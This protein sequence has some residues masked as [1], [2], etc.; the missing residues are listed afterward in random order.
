MPTE[1]V[2]EV[3]RFLSSDAPKSKLLR[4]F[5]V[6]QSSFLPADSERP[7]MDLPD[8][9][10]PSLDRPV[11]L[12][13]FNKLSAA[14][15]RGIVSKWWEKIDI[16]EKRSSTKELGRL[17]R[18]VEGKGHNRQKLIGF[19]LDKFWPQGL[20]LSQISDLDFCSLL[21]QPDSF[22]WT[23]MA[24]ESKEIDSAVFQVIPE[25]LICALKQDLQ[26]LFTI[27]TCL[28]PHPELPLLVL[29]VQLFDQKRCGPESA[30][31]PAPAYNSTRKLISRAPTYVV[32]PFNISSVGFSF[33]TDLYTKL[34]INSICK[35]VHS[36][37][38]V[39]L[40]KVDKLPVRNL[41]TVAFLHGL[42]RYAN[43]QGVWRAY[44][45][46][47]VDSS[48][49]DNPHNHEIVQGREQLKW[50]LQ[51]Q[52]GKA[53]MRFKGRTNI[54]EPTATSAEKLRYKSLLPVPRVDFIIESEKS[55]E[56]QAK[57]KLS[58]W[59]TD[60]FGGLHELCDKGYMDINRVPG[61]LTGENGP[62]SGK[63]INGEFYSEDI[64][65]RNL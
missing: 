51:S 34:I 1:I 12:R 40:A 33:G 48:P 25:Q 47:K 10:I 43:A 28:R 58:L 30:Q 64:S 55:P 31:N 13:K 23:L 37:N 56:K 15:I 19:I 38:K 61:W 39:K 26:P 6:N 32:L 54:P 63:I 11:I 20:N 65:H 50:S 44:A 62:R 4:Q 17:I 60:V 16:R 8:E 18:K 5:P 29:R 45:D 22:K 21:E 41:N 3:K 53:M 42:S 52:T 7:K 59:G 57:F 49:L 36:K 9:F 35:S 46:R 27:H 14:A 2:V 24:A